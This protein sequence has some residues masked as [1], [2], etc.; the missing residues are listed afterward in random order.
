MNVANGTE[1]I[2]NTETIAGGN[3][4]YKS[5]EIWNLKPTDRGNE[6]ERILSETEYQD[7]YNIGQADNGKFPVIDFQK[8]NDVVSLKTIDPRL[9]SYQGDGLINK[10]ESYCEALD[11]EITV[12]DVLANKTLDLRIPQG[13]SSSINFEQ[14][15][16]LMKEYD[17]IIKIK[18]F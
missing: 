5:E 7:W 3:K 12:D 15:D 13:T 10:I 18:E 14:I 1:V 2:T 9:K 8:G 17:I 6:I 11:R 16:A 4:N